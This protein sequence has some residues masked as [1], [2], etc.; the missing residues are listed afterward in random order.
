MVYSL[1]LRRALAIAD[2]LQGLPARLPK[3]W[4]FEELSVDP[5]ADFRVAG[6]YDFS[7]DLRAFIFAVNYLKMPPS[8]DFLPGCPL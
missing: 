5:K 1:F 3:R 2:G 6:G 8:F 4:V 7:K